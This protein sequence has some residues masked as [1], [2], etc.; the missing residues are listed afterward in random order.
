M[1]VQKPMTAEDL[2]N[3]PDDGDLIPGFTCNV[4]DIFFLGD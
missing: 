2:W 4:D 1:A 3:L